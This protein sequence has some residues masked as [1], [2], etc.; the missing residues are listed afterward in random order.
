ML[1]QPYIPMINPTQDGFM[2]YMCVYLCFICLFCWFSFMVYSLQRL[3]PKLPARR[4]ASLP[5]P[6]FLT[7]RDPLW[8]PDLQNWKTI[9]ACCF[10]PPSL[11]QFIIWQWKTNKKGLLESNSLCFYQ[12]PWAENMCASVSSSIK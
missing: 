7:R 9:N 12:G 5:T 4:H 2:M 11:W 1:N 8:T 6:C 10:K 3:P